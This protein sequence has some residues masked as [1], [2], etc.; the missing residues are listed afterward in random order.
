VVHGTRDLAIP[1]ERGRELASLIPGA[2]F[3]VLQGANHADDT[4]GSSRLY[5]LIDAF[6]REHDPVAGR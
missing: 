6:L 4:T 3:E 5:E 1:I 2:R